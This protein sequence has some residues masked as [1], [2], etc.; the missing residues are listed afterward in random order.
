M[1]CRN[2]DSE[3]AVC[4][5]P[6]PSITDR[7]AEWFGKGESGIGSRADAALQLLEPSLVLAL[8]ARLRR[9]RIGPQTLWACRGSLSKIPM[10]LNEGDRAGVRNVT[11]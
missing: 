9:V 1:S 2:V 4:A 7:G 10:A 3:R 11:F 8:R 5:N 6:T